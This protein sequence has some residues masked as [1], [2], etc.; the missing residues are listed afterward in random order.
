MT[1]INIAQY[2]QL[3][4]LD[5][6]L[7]WAVVSLQAANRDVNN[8]DLINANYPDIRPEASTLVSWN[9][10]LDSAGQPYLT[11]SATFPLLDSGPLESAPLIAGVTAYSFFDPPPQRLTIP[12]TGQGM[13]APPIPIEVDTL[14]KLVAWLSLIAYQLSEYLIY[15]S[16]LNFA[17][18]TT[19]PPVTIN[20]YGLSWP[21]EHPESVVFAPFAGATSGTEF[22]SAGS[23]AGAFD[24]GKQG[25]DN[26]K[27]A[28]KLEQA[29]EDQSAAAAN[30][31]SITAPPEY[32]KID[33]LPLCKEQNPD[34]KAYARSLI[35]FAVTRGKK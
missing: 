15:C 12:A 26:E 6:A 25:P 2:E 32:K 14:E 10:Q 20:A 17:G 31:P 8:P 4:S 35:E 29:R 7:V 22:S 16:A 3:Q 21:K 24:G 9:T 19:P 30:P 5:Q 1:V 34:E 27:L 28:E 23:E 11:Y 13:P 33:T 18:E